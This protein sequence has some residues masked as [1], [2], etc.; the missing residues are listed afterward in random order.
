MSG[1]W[2]LGAWCLGRDMANLGS[3]QHRN[4]LSLP[5]FTLHCSAFCSGIPEC[6]RRGLETQLPETQPLLRC[7]AC[8]PL[9]L[10]V[11]LTPPTGVFEA[12]TAGREHGG[13][14]YVV[15][16]GRTMK[17]EAE[18][19]TCSSALCICSSH[20]LF[21][22]ADAARSL[23]DTEQEPAPLPRAPLPQLFLPGWAWP[24]SL[25][26]SSGWPAGLLPREPAALALPS[27]SCQSWSIGAGWA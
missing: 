10:G 13:A 21:A 8:P 2:G 15:F 14:V 24:A 25:R 26:G 12:T 18:R 23:A 7:H 27:G 3:R 22:F 9:G 20:L 19:G 11:G 5:H 16:P 1:S 17:K 4:L 6:R